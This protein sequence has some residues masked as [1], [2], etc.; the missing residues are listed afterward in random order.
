MSKTFHEKYMDSKRYVDYGFKVTKSNQ[1]K[2]TWRQK[3]TINDYSEHL[4]GGEGK[5]G[6]ANGTNQYVQPRLK[7]RKNALQK[8]FGQGKGTG[9]PKLKGVFITTGPIDSKIKITYDKKG[10]PVVRGKG[11]NR[12]RQIR[13][14]FDAEG[15]I[16]NSD[17]EVAR[18]LKKVKPPHNDFGRETLH[19][20]VGAHEMIANIERDTIRAEVKRLMNVTAKGGSGLAPDLLEAVIFRHFPFT[21]SAK[22]F[23]DKR[24]LALTSVERKKAQRKESKRLKKKERNSNYK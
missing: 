19:I 13:I 16:K 17:S 9:F 21:E 12:Y 1:K 18:V 24:A 10:K 14:T 20:Q 23:K 4:F 2:L 15:L 6:I 8:S 5:G 7:K 11:E 3:K 22:D